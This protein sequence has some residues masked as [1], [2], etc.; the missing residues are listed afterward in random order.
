MEEGIIPT[1]PSAFARWVSKPLQIPGIP[2][3]P[4]RHRTKISAPVSAPRLA[5][6]KKARSRIP[7]VAAAQN[8]LMKM[9]GISSEPH[10]EAAD[11]ECY[12]NIFDEGLTEAQIKL[13]KELFLANEVMLAAE[14]A[15][16]EAA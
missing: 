12:I 4:G 3:T 7:A 6:K 11:F 15:E 1:G 10:L 13:I 9:L 14:L 5:S 8:V 2:C 16:Q